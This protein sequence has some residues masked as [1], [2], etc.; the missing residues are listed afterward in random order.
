MRDP[1]SKVTGDKERKER[2]QEIVDV[3]LREKF[4]KMVSSK[5]PIKIKL[6]ILLLKDQRK[7]FEYLKFILIRKTTENALINIKF[8][9]Y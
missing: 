4:F 1:F 5:L 2:V 9:D 7:C 8:N 3:L 6:I